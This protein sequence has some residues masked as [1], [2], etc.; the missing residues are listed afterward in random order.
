MPSD[1]VE[2][3]RDRGST[4]RTV[5]EVTVEDTK[6]GKVAATL[7]ASDRMTSPT[8]NEIEVEDTKPGKV[9]A[10]LKASDQ[11][12]GQTFNDVGRMDY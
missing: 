12:T 9:A 7:K 2:E 8:F 11:M 10:T 4:G 6:P 5:V 1:I 3:T